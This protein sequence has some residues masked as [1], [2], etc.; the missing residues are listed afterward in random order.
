MFSKIRVY[1][2]VE[3]FDKNSQ[4]MGL[5]VITIFWKI[6]SVLNLKQFNFLELWRDLKK[7][8]KNSFPW[9]YGE[10]WKKIIKNT[11]L[12]SCQNHVYGAVERFEKKIIKNTCLPN[13][14]EM[15][16]I[17]KN[18]RFRTVEIF[19]EIYVHG[20]VEIWNNSLK[21]IHVYGP[22]ERFKKFFKNPSLWNSGEIW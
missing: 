20:A 22:V 1:G 3:R 2:S 10:I 13:C 21:K 6:P 7:I 12:R 9:S 11:C 4:F 14:G 5:W 16:T 17:F 8:F 19:L 15:W 18:S